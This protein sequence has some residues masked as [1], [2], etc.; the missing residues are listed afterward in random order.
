LSTNFSGDQPDFSD[1]IS[2]A[3]AAQLRGVSRQAIS[4]LIRAG[5]LKTFE[6]GGHI[7]V[8]RSETMSFRHQTAGRPKASKKM[9]ELDRILKTLASCSSRTRHEVFQRLRVEFPI[10]ALETKIG[11]SAELILEAFTRADPFTKRGIRGIIGEFCFARY[12]L[13]NSDR[14]TISEVPPR[15]AYDYIVDDGEGLVRVQVKLQRR[16]EDDERP[17]LAIEVRKCFAPG[18]YLVEPQRTRSGKKKG[19]STRPYRFGDYDILAVVMEP[20]TKR[21]DYFMYTVA[22]WLIPDP[23]Y[24]NQ[25]FEYQPIPQVPNE[26]WTDRFETCVEWLRRGERKTIGGLVSP[27]QRKPRKSS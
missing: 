15:S 3:E 12:A 14:W 10:H 7:L 25:F 24:P 13:A 1:W 27:I 2:Q 20:L 4:K 22:N 17:V 19:E 8:S 11:L 23:I 16:K 21:W 26:D 9:S 5:R 18:L 6:V